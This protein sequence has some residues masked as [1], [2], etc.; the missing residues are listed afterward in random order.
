MIHP[1]ITA[2]RRLYPSRPVV[3]TAEAGRLYHAVALLARAPGF[4]KAPYQVPDTL[5]G[6]FD[7]LTVLLG[8]LCLRFSTLPEGQGQKTSQQLFDIMFHQFELNLREAGI[9]DL[10]VPKQMRRMIQSFYGRMANY[11]ELLNTGQSHAELAEAL[12]RNIYGGTGLAPAQALSQWVINVWQPLLLNFNS[13]YDISI[14]TDNIQVLCEDL[15]SNWSG[16]HDNLA[17]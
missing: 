16:P 1:I 14:L 10:S 5:D 3:S 7:L 6:R 13:L 4:Y 2:I 9:G 11:T 8:L 15:K 12:N 17:A